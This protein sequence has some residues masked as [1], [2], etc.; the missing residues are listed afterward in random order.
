MPFPNLFPICFLVVCYLLRTKVEIEV[1]LKNVR[2]VGQS[3]DK[4]GHF[5]PLLV[6]PNKTPYSCITLNDNTTKIDVLVEIGC[7]L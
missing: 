2:V 3:S 5:R 7:L 6:I 4:L 1:Q